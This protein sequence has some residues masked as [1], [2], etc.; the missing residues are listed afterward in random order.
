MCI[1][2]RNVRTL[3]ATGAARI[4]VEVLHKARVN[5]MG[6]QEVRWHGAGEVKMLDYTILW[7]GSPEGSARQ[8]GVGLAVEKRT[9]SAL[10]SW[11]PVSE[12]L[13]IA[14]FSHT[15]GILVVFV[16]YALHRMARDI[17]IKPKNIKNR[18]ETVKESF[19][20]MDM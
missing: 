16:V 2:D 6:L 13:L 7:S 10:L 18:V 14:K 1:R 11:Q 4:L 15:F 3:F 5:L 12:R 20:L 9:S 19:V 8:S 17:Y